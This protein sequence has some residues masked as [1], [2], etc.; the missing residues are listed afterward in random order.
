MKTSIIPTALAVAITAST[1]TACVT[2]DPLASEIATYAALDSDG[3]AQLSGRAAA[4]ADELVMT[5]AGHPDVPF[6]LVSRPDLEGGPGFSAADSI[7]SITEGFAHKTISRMLVEKLGDARTTDEPLAGASTDGSNPSFSFRVDNGHLVGSTQQSTT[8]ASNGLTASAEV[9]TTMDVTACPAADG[10]VTAT[11]SFRTKGSAA[12][13]TAE[14]SGEQW[15]A[16]DFS[17]TATGRVGDD[18]NLLSLDIASTAEITSGMGATTAGGTARD[19]INFASSWT[20]TLPY[21]KGEPGKISPNA[22]PTITRASQSVGV[23]EKLQLLKS[24]A[25]MTYSLA[26]TVFQSA[27]EHW[28]SGACVQ[29]GIAADADLPTVEKGSSTGVTVTPIAKADNKPTGGTMTAERQEGAGTIDP[30]DARPTPTEYRYAAPDADADDTTLVLFTATSKRGIGLLTQK[31]QTTIP[32]WVIH[33]TIN[34]IETYAMKCGTLSG[35]W[36]VTSS[37]AGWYQATSWAQVDAETA[38]GSYGISGFANGFP[39]S[40]GGAITLETLDD[41]SLVMHFLPGETGYVGNG[42]FPVREDPEICN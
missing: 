7:A 30:T 9:G 31:F 5:A 29:M 3:M 14:L 37:G 34:G 11:V 26:T 22:L 24:T 10:S 25:G 2:P 18:A 36:Y 19:G 33:E 39:F 6:A 4:L 20:Y 27:Q 35:E 21:E 38:T 15:G 28:R 23:S 16:L 13:S 41:G 40:G 42:V 17:M 8:A 32:G 12:K 1:L